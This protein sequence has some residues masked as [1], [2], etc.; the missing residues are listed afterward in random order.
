MNK[1]NKLNSTA[2]RFSTLI[3]NKNGKKSVFCAKIISATEK[4]VSFWDVNSEKT[5]RVA[6]NTVAGFQSGK[7][8]FANV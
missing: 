6:T 4:F 3:T 5:R 7:V 8:R 2:G 1:V